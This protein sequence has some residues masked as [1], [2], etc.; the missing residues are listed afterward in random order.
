MFHLCGWYESLDAAGVLTNIAAMS[1]QSL[2]TDG[3]YIQVPKELPNLSGYACLINDSSVVPQAQI[4]SPSLRTLANL[5]V[6]PIVEALTFGA[7]PQFVNLAKVPQAL[8]PGEDLEFL[9]L[10]NPSS[11]VGNYGLIWLSDGK[12]QPITG[13]VFTVRCTTSISLSAGTWVNGNI[14]FSQTLPNGTYQVVGMRARGTNLVA[15]RLV[16]K[17]AAWRPG[18]PAINS[19]SDRGNWHMRQGDLT[20]FGSFEQTNPP[21]VDALGVTDSSQTIFLDLI[22]TA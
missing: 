3:D 16:F 21:S 5:D 18:V 7:E 8:T 17:G 11:A 12:M 22:K 1:D 20:V 19:V 10:Q 9:V 4:Q 14:T 15:A 13:E 2:H 6:E